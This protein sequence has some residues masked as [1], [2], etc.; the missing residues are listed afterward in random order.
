MQSVSADLSAAILARQRQPQARVRV[1]WDGDGSFTT[2][3]AGYT[4]DISDDVVSIDLSRELST[5]LPTA[6]KLFSGSAAAQA[7]ITLG[8]RDPGGDPAK[9]GG[10]FYSPVNSA[11]PL[12]AKQR[13][14]RAVTVEFGMVTA[15]G[16]TEYVVVLVGTIRS[17]EVSAGGRQ[18]T[19]VVADRSETMRKQIQLP[20]IIA[21]GDVAGAAAIKR[22]GL[23][24]T[25]LAD[26]VARKCGYYASPPQ[27]SQCMLSV[28]HHGSGYPEVGRSRNTTASTGRCCPTAPPR[29]SPRRP[30][31]CRGSTPT[32]AAARR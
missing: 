20:M 32:A 31:G 3:G 8:H 24:T 5:D 2:V 7:T 4:D 30:A 14:G 10:W 22:P 6:A 26:Y 16:T 21:D 1:D 19:M 12:Y 28:T 11:S 25:W 18:A 29:G 27:R 13:K 15:A 17:L 9:H 23:N